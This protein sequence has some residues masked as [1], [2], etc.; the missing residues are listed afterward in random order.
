MSDGLKGSQK[1]MPASCFSISMTCRH[2]SGDAV[3]LQAFPDKIQAGHLSL[4]LDYQFDPGKESDGVSV[5]VPVTV[6]MQLKETDLDWLV[7]GM[8]REKCI[9][10]VK[11]LPKSVR[12]NFVP[13]PDYIDRV[14]ARIK[15]GEGDL[16]A[17]LA[18]QLQVLLA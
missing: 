8:L 3:N 12:K 2:S 11:A 17:V 18:T 7:P 1:K 9:A 14:L 13:V 10:M 6:L 4:E 16:K 15:L 5:D